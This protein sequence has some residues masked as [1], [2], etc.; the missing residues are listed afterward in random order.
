M[1]DATHS[2]INDAHSDECRHTLGYVTSHIRL[3]HG[4]SHV[5]MSHVAHKNESRHVA[6]ENG[7]RRT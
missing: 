4:M 2:Y 5:R 3:S 7:S 6:R 1:K